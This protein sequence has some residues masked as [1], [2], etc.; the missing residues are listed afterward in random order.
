MRARIILRRVAGLSQEQVAAELGVSKACVNKWSQRFDRE[1]LAGLQDRPGRGRRPSIAP[2]KVEQVMLS[3][4]SVHRIWRANDI[5][6]HVVKTSA[7]RGAISW[8]GR[9]GRAG[10]WPVR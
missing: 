5:K 4:D 7:R 3:P 8:S 6:P 1:G 2:E 9:R 10:A